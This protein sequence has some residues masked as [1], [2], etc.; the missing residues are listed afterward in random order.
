MDE[1]LDFFE[2]IGLLYKM[3][4]LDIYPIWHR[5]AGTASFRILAKGVSNPRTS[6][7]IRG[8]AFRSPDLVTSLR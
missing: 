1:V 6:A 7:Q 5:T 4:Y 2:Y 8:S 3:K